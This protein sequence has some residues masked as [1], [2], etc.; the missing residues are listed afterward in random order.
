MRAEFRPERVDFRPDRADFR[1]D[2]A[3]FRPERAWGINKQTD[4]VPL[5]STGLCPLRGRCPK[6]K[7]KKRKKLTNKD[8]IKTLKIVREEKNLIV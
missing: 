2:R 1:P 3:D 8:E 7:R 6:R 4:E 5:C